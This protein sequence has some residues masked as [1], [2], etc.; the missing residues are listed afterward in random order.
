MGKIGAG[1]ARG[2]G[3]RS[4]EI[5]GGGGELTGGG[6]PSSPPSCV[7]MV[8]PSRLGKPDVSS[9]FASSLA[10]LDT[11]TAMQYATAAQR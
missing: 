2:D 5:G 8:G 7:F 10:Q 3:P 4:A 1:K 11:R 9:V 6:A